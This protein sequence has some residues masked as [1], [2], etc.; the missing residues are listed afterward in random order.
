MSFT[1]TEYPAT[2]LTG[3]GAATFFMSDF[4][5]R[6]TGVNGLSSYYTWLSSNNG[7]S[8]T[9]YSGLN[10]Q[11]NAVRYGAYG[12]GRWVAFDTGS[13]RIYPSSDGATYTSYVATG[14][15]SYPKGAAYGN[16]LFVAVSAA[17]IQT[18]PTGLSGTWTIVTP[19][20]NWSVVPQALIWTGTEFWVPTTDDAYVFTSPDGSNWTRYARS[21]ASFAFNETPAFNG[22]RFVF[23]RNGAAY[24]SDDGK[25]WVAATTDIST[26]LYSCSKV[27]WGGYNFFVFDTSTAKFIYSL[28]GDTWAE[29]TVS[30]VYN[31]P[32]CVGQSNV[33]IGASSAGYGIRFTDAPPPPVGDAIVSV[34]ISVDAEGSFGPIS[35]DGYIE[36]S[37]NVDATGETTLPVVIG[38]ADIFPIIVV[39]GAGHTSVYGNASHSIVLLVA[40]TGSTDVGG[41]GNI[42]IFP[43]V[44]AVATTWATAT[45][46][47][48]VEAEISCEGTH[49]QPVV[50]EPIIVATGSVG[51]AATAV[52]NV[53]AEVSATGMLVPVGV[54]SISV[55][56]V[57]LA[58]G[59]GTEY[60]G[61]AAVSVDVVIAC[62]AH[63][64][65][66]VIGVA[67]VVVEPSIVASGITVAPGVGV[68]TI[69]VDVMVAAFGTG[70]E[71]EAANSC[72]VS[73]GDPVRVVV[74]A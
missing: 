19:P 51:V 32:P 66:P 2:W 61:A 24:Y 10:W 36:L 16:S 41:Y 27:L 1:V 43:T 49:F 71:R 22:S 64:D 57:I 31:N 33:I 40:A 74:Y 68:A 44:S 65:A 62:V 59:I 17:D 7:V 63:T 4:A 54:A 38:A 15:T 8:F 6:V 67:S 52:V 26:F 30:Q 48:L 50:V 11:Y 55:A 3:S 53:V 20:A 47:V 60:A 42:T 28:D 23:A 34:V 69:V 37:L 29:Q 14:W 35:G 46:A 21:G 56:P 39:S 73:G 58:Q 45:V 18:S 13:Y 9:R 25:Y 70:P 12:N 72:F 5:G